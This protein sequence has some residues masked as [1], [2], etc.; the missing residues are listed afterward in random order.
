MEYILLIVGL[1]LLI[2]GANYFVEGASNIA[3]L[4][5]IPPILIGLTVVAFGTRAIQFIILK[6]QHGNIFL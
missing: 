1:G 5:K 6:V 2:E 3:K 4:L